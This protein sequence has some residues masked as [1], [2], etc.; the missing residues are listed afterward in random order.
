[1][2]CKL[3]VEGFPPSFSDEE[4]AKVFSAFG[5]VISAVIARSLTNESMC[6]GAVKMAKLEEAD[7]AIK[8]LHRTHIDGRCIL[9]FHDVWPDQAGARPK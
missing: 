6:F 5:T 4:L 9:I 1:M 7:K 8:A 3:Y 2:A